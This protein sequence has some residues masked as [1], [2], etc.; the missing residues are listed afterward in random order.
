VVGQT[1]RDIEIICVN[2]ASTDNCGEILREYAEKDAQVRVIEFAENKG[3]S[4][5][6]NA[7]IGAANGEY[8]MNFSMP[9]RGKHA[10]K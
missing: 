6:R 9:K 2:D 4:A 8:I 10:P 5:A 3:A 7:G 1:L